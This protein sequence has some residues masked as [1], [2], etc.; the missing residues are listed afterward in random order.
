[1]QPSSSNRLSKIPRIRFTEKTSL[2]TAEVAA[3]PYEII[4]NFRRLVKNYFFHQGVAL[5]FVYHNWGNHL[6]SFPKCAILIMI[7]KEE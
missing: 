5:P 3:S 6:Q 7:T 2:K 4:T 1:M